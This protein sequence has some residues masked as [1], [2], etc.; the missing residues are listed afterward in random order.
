M[1]KI[2]DSVVFLTGASSGIG[3]ALAYEFS[4]KGAK[5]VISARRSAELDRVKAT[6]TYPD[7]VQ[8]LT[9]DLA[10]NFS[11]IQKAK[12]AETFFGPIDILVNCGGISN[13][14]KVADTSMDVD[15][16]LMEVNYFSAIALT[17]TLL[18]SMLKRKKG[19]QVVITS[20]SGIISPPKRSSYAA[21][22]HAL[23]GFYEALRAEYHDEGQK[24]TLVLPGYIR[25][26]ISY[27]ALKGD[28]STQNK[29]DANQ[30]NGMSPED[31]AAQ[32]IKA[33]EQNKEEVYIGG[34]KEVTGIYLKR[35]FPSLFS[36][37]VRKAET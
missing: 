15:R 26:N 27:N 22:K 4:K 1:T 7:N 24:V 5:L 32:T 18:P 10:D 6:C 20:A 14:D 28:G 9:I 17:K 8:T 35:F 36:K 2:K 19:H 31:C 33:I 37:I 21:S 12:E 34:F 30:D 29:M 25:T 13:R 3:E 11:V 23:H 16:K